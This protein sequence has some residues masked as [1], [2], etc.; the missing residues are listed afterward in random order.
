M[1]AMMYRRLEDGFVR[2]DLCRH[3]CTIGKDSSGRCRVRVNMGGE[4]VTLVYGRVIAEHTDPV[5]KKPLFH[6]LPGSTTYSI[7]TVGCNFRCRNCQNHGIAQFSPTGNGTVPGEYVE[8]SEIVRR[9]VNAG[10]S[11]ISYTYTEPT[12]YFEY[13][14]DTAR[15]ARQAGL[16]NIFVTNGYITPEALDIIAPC[17]DASNIDLKGYS[18]NFYNRMAGAALA[19]VLECIIDYHRRGIWIEITTLVIAGENDSVEQ[20][21]G[22]A[23]FIATKLGSDVPWHL[24]RFFPQHQMPNHPV[25]PASAL[26][27]GVSAARSAGLRFV[28]EGNFEGGLCDTICPQ[29]S[30][31]IIKRRGYR[32]VMSEDFNGSCPGCGSHI[33][34]VFD[35]TGD[36]A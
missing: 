14:L 24:S 35:V 33:A 7:A 34:G 2:C 11:S 19:D 17:I 6:F 1:E 32:S 36:G 9:A 5:E 25:T 18:A 30:R 10:C 4:L 29:C 12:I 8:P 27:K 13:A 21:A 3:R 16:K 28:Y 15:L 23:E 26:A 22:I 31:G 20:L